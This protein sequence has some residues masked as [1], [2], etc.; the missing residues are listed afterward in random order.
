MLERRLCEYLLKKLV[1]A[2][3]PKKALQYNRRK[4]CRKSKILAYYKVFGR[5]LLF[6][7]ASLLT[8]FFLQRSFSPWLPAMVKQ[9]NIL[10]INNFSCISILEIISFL[11]QVA[12]QPQNNRKMNL[13]FQ[14]SVKLLTITLQ[15]ET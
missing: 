6:S 13:C 3:T 4:F 5:F 15:Q 12:I 14:K 11:T 8:F 2:S 10:I 9:L 1:Q 7:Y